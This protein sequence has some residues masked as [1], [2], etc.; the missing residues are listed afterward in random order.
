MFHQMLMQASRLFQNA[1]FGPHFPSRNATRYP[2]N[3]NGTNEEIVT[4]GGK[5]F[6]KKDTVL[7]KKDHG[8]TVSYTWF[9]QEF[10][11][12]DQF[13]FV[14]DFHHVHRTRAIG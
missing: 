1:N 5:R 4:I 9:R 13:V 8:M 3:Y 6:L 11:I 14:T 10:P 2:P 12:T 7:N